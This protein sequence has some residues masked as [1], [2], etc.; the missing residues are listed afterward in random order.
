MFNSNSIWRDKE[1]QIA[2]TQLLGIKPWSSR[3]AANI[4]TV[5]AY[6]QI[7]SF[8]FY[9][10]GFLRWN[11][12]IAGSQH[13]LTADGLVLSSLGQASLGAPVRGCNPAVPTS[14]F[15]TPGSQL[16]FHPCMKC[17]PFLPT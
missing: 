17:L 2:I 4:P 10:A 14:L 5:H 1:Q 12:V 16:S 3:R 15:I 11:K 13:A 9:L 6:T 8:L 7:L